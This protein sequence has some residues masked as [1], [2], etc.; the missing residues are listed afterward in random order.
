MIKLINAYTLSECL[1]T[2]ADEIVAYEQLGQRNII[3]CED[4]LTLVAERALMRRLGGTFLT[5][6][7]TFSRFLK[8]DR[9][10]LSREGSVMAVGEIMLALQ[11]ENAL[12]CF[13]SQSSV[14]S[15]AKCIYEQL[16]QFG[17]SELSPQSLKESVEKL[18]EDMLKNKMVDLALIYEK[19][20]EFLRT[21][22]F[23]DEGKYLTLLPECIK[24]TGG[25]SETNVFFLC[26]SS[27][28]KQAKR[29][30]AAAMDS[31]KNT[32]G[33]F[34]AGD[35]ELYTNQAYG[36]FYELAKERK[37]KRGVAMRAVN[38]GMPLTGE[39]EALRKTLF[40]M[41]ALAGD[42]NSDRLATDS[43]RIYAAP[44]RAG[45]AE[46]A[47]VY[48]RKAL[49]ENPSLHYRDF[50]VLTP[51][52]EE[53]SLAIAKVFGEYG[54]PYSMDERISL[55]QHPLAKFILSVMNAV[56]EHFPP[57]LVDSVAQNVFFGDGDN[58]RNYL[59][60]YANFRG[61]VFKALKIPEDE[62]Q[63][64][65]FTRNYGSAEYLQNSK[66]KMEKAFSLFKDARF[67]REY[68]HAV[69][70]LMDA[71]NAGQVLNEL[72]SSAKNEGM[73]SYLG[74]IERK[75][76]SVL[77]EAESLAGGKEMS[78]EDFATLLGDGLEA[79]EIAPNPLRL[80]AVFVGD[81]TDSRIERVN[82]LFA[83]GLTDAVPR[84]SDDANLITDQDKIKL[85]EI[86]AVLEPMV[87]EV[88]MRN[89]ESVGLNLCTFTDK[90]Y[91]SYA[92]SSN[93]DEPAVSEVFRYVKAAFVRK[94]GGEILE[95]KGIP[96]A[97][98]AYR[99]SAL[100][101]AARL[102]LVEKN[103]YESGVTKDRRLFS[104]LYEALARQDALPD[105]VD[106]RVDPH[107]YIEQ[108]EELF[109]AKGS[110]SPSTLETYF[111]CPY[112]CFA[113]R[114]LRLEERQ[115][116]AVLS[117]D[118]GNFIHKLLEEMTDEI[119]KYN[120]EESFAKAA[121]DRGMSLMK[122]PKLI[123]AEDTLAGVYSSEKLLEEGVEVAKAVYRQVRDSAF[124][125]ITKEKVVDTPNVHGKVDRV[126]ENDR[127]VRV[128]DYKTGTISPD[129][130]DYYSGRKIQ[131]ELYMSA[132]KGE[133]IP[134]G[135]LYFPASVAFREKEDGRYR[136]Q[137]F[138]N[139]DAEALLSGDK[140]LAGDK[141]SDHFEA[142][143][144]KNRSDKVM[145]SED[146]CEF[147]DYGVYLSKGATEEIREGYVAPSPVKQSFGSSCTW[148]KFGGMCG[149]HKD[150]LSVRN[151]PSA[152]A[153][154]VVQCV[155]KH[156]EGCENGSGDGVNTASSANDGVNTASSANGGVNTACS[157]DGGMDSVD[158]TYGGGNTASSVGDGVNTANTATEGGKQDE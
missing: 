61:G 26:Y 151:V 111:D 112:K 89:R 22:D 1:E 88:N 150:Q 138:L 27:F 42:K 41:E 33:V 137:G 139:G 76:E 107:K 71:F 83:L 37:D 81:I 31:A 4:R 119:A 45:E 7:T 129:V 143:L 153:K 141:K 43:V 80:D 116:A 39:A 30:L 104:S 12:K 65:E 102:L 154:Q 99:S 23:L 48:I 108:G 36:S 16:A 70:E 53:Y 106:G 32:V 18:P 50:A 6:I 82:V 114:G 127:F 49:Q 152:N 66:S 59:L 117:V 52:V 84:A 93:G 63:F 124:D 95:E 142:A 46:F 131:M 58:Y 100:S 85:K 57:S 86:Q 68:C 60:R 75:V 118:T 73:R 13:T 128:V 110:L 44:N 35:E 15:G 125:V 120:D 11:K 140:T 113:S 72:I 24:N 122:N 145:S 149:F 62:E 25:M 8:T 74:Q 130:K 132:V 147:L 40:S 69:K 123:S 9:K 146:F 134:A 101:P 38:M 115:E 34:L 148:C 77:F 144:E 5:E 157:V 19:Y 155:K 158:S 133:K 136:M 10:V 55:K 54:I 92:L 87:E 20:D 79:T 121:K 2:V 21:E 47:A 126:D 97:D 105:G 109:L 103:A 98:Y 90:L 96:A 78:L 3:F 14:L 56:C 156:K 51:S 67:G 28:T 94:D 17:A 29:T 135:V 64:S 91:L